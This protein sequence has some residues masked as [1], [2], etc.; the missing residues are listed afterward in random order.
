MSLVIINDT[1]LASIAD[2]IREA[3]GND[4]TYT[5]AEMI[6][7]ISNKPLSK[8]CIE[9][10]ITEYSSTVTTVRESAFYKCTALTTVDLSKCTYIG[11][12]AFYSCTSLTTV[13]LRSETMA[14][15]SKDAFTNTPIASGT[16]YIYV[17]AALIDTYKADSKWS[18]YANQFRA[19]ED[20]PDICG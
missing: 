1:I 9:K 15:L 2:A 3:N 7:A 4:N 16:G 10:T 20:Y 17:P 11:E 13:V 8:S 5:P 18:T 14:T 6:P 12:V 19:I